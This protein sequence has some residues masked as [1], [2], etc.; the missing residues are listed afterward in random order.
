MDNKRGTMHVFLNMRSSSE[1]AGDIT[2][3]K[4]MI[5]SGVARDKTDKILQMQFSNSTGPLLDCRTG[6]HC[7]CCRQWQAR[8]GVAASE[9]VAVAVAVAS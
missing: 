3:V 9:S 8:P 2:T 5:S 7:H 4:S 6:I 1:S